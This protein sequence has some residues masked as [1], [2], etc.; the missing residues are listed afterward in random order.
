[1]KL[2]LK[3]SAILAPLVLTS[4]AMAQNYPAK[5]VTLMVP[6][7]LG[8]LSDVIARKVNVRINAIVD[9]MHRY[10]P[11]DVGARPAHAHGG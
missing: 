8:G 6:Y 4:A 5:P 9:V 1:M 7:P 3:L 2:L 11:D 10:Q